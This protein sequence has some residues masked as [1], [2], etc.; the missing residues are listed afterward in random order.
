MIFKAKNTGTY[1]IL[2]VYDGDTVEVDMQGTPEKIRFVGADTPE[3]KDPR[4]PVQCYGPEASAYTHKMLG[5]GARVRLVAD[6]LTSN[7]DLYGRLLRYVYLTDG[8]LYNKQLIQKGFA[9]AYVG[10]PFTKTADFI[11]TQDLAKD[12]KTGLWASCPAS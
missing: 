11:K 1:K 3:T 10:F 12:S 9:H 2:E 7:R 8:T 4:K 5:N 6:P